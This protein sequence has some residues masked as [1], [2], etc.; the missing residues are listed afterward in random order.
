MKSFV[1]FLCIYMPALCAQQLLFTYSSAFDS[2]VGLST[3]THALANGEWYHFMAVSEEYGHQYGLRIE[4]ID[5]EGNVL[6]EAFY[7]LPDTSLLVY[8][9]F[10]HQGTLHLLGTFYNP[11]MQ[12]GGIWI[13]QMGTDLSIAN[14]YARSTG[15]FYA[16][17]LTA[18]QTMDRI[19]IAGTLSNGAFT[20]KSFTL[21]LDESFVELDWYD[22]YT[23]DMHIGNAFLTDDGYILIGDGLWSFNMGHV[24]QR[25]LL[26]DELYLNHQTSAIMHTNGFIYTLRRR[27]EIESGE[28]DLILEKW[29]LDFKLKGVLN[30][31]S[32]SLSERPAFHQ[33]IVQLSN[34]TIGFCAWESKT[35]IGFPFVS[36][37]STCWYWLANEQLIPMTS[38]HWNASEFVFLNTLTSKGDNRL[39]ASGFIYEESSQQLRSFCQ[40]LLFLPLKSPERR[41][42]R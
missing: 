31:G 11:A 1:F 8:K 14:H 25:E 26:F 12:Q 21:L 30:V 9:S 7:E 2:P 23:D 6:N 13:A 24:L 41:A 22:L 28:K 42:Y 33:S 5:P 18:D 39:I 4:H 17:R 40:S 34:G 37:P 35:M 36:A 29:T 20:E 15:S 10:M 38:Y 32:A 3:H 16:D 27:Y 19:L